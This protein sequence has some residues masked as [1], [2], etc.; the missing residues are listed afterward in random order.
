MADGDWLILSGERVRFAISPEAE[1]LMRLDM[2]PAQ[3]FLPHPVAIRMTPAEARDIARRLTKTA[4]EA[5]A[6]SPGPPS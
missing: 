4:D 6:R 2:G 3:E 1:V 5:E